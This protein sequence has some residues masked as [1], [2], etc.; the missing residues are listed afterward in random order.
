MAEKRRLQ[1]DDLYRLSFVSDPQISPCGHNIAYVKAHIDEKTKEYRSHIWMVPV[2]GGKP[3]QYTSGPKSDTSPRW[4]PD[5]SMIAFLSDRN[6]EKQIFVMPTNGGEARQITNMR[7]GAGAP[8]WSP[9]GTKIAFTSAIDIEDK[10][11]DLEKPLDKKD[12]DALEKKKRDEPT[13]VTRLHMKADM[14]MGL[15]PPRYSQIFVVDVE[16]KTGVKQLTFGNFN[17]SM[18]QWSPCGKYIVFSANRREDADWEPYL[19]DIYMVPAEGGELRKLTPSTG[20][21]SS[22]K[23]TPDGKFVVYAG[24]NMEHGGPTLTKLW[25]VPVEGGSPILLTGSFDRSF[26]DRCAGD[27]RL[28]GS[29]NGPTFSK[30]GKTIYFLAS[31][32]GRSSIYKV[33]TEGGDVELV[34]GGD[35]QI[36]GFTADDSGTKFAIAVSTPTLPGD[37]GFYDVLGGTERTLTSVNEW[38]DEVFIVAPETI[39]FKA[40]DGLQEY[41]WI[42]KPVGFKQ[43]VKYPAVLQIHGGPH[44]MYGY[45]FFFEFQ[46]LAN[47]G[48]VVF[49]TNP[50][51]G[52][53]FGQEFVKAVCGDYG[54]MDFEDLMTW[55][56]VAVE[57]G[58]I[59]E[60]RIGVTGGSYGGFMTNWIVGHTSRFAAAVTQRSISNWLSFHGVSDIGYTFV[61][62]ELYCDVW[63]DTQKLWDFSPLK[64]VDNVT[65][66][67]LII[68]SENDMRCPIEQGEQLYVALKKQKKEVEMV[69]FP[70][71]NHELS[72][73]GRPVLRVAR[74]NHIVRWFDSHIAKNPGDYEPS[75]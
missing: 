53:G 3:R 22:P 52:E 64:Y 19:T 41:G 24:H 42:M 12:K 31:D 49:Y 27:S 2:T 70:G 63:K 47:K 66:P 54:G 46:L 38:L 32:H 33:P 34:L 16:G 45:S 67:L 11:E 72:R 29:D 44:S 60:N 71:S 39:P 48:Y 57:Q 51:G 13:V 1:T 21:C 58:Y 65:T 10:P 50:R 75:L 35:R 61:E 56:D 5:G 6:G 20:P 55:T 69:R 9:D 8:V 74:L 68:H 62:R 43:G 4:S 59:D 26:G 40:K 23:F 17:H 14:A 7:R 18:P 15:L 25:K 37:V 28:G 36:F 30:D 73:S